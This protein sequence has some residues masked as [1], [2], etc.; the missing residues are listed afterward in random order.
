MI[1]SE[2]LMEMASMPSLSDSPADCTKCNRFHPQERVRRN[3]NS[4]HANRTKPY[5]PTCLAI[6]IREIIPLETAVYGH[7]L[8]VLRE[9]I[10][11]ESVDLIYFAP[12]FTS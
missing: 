4:V 8:Q 12:R 6:D 7:K 10:T 3:A 5:L 11:D 9:H 1:M 2:T